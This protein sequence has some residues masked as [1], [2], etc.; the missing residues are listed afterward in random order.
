MPGYCLAVTVSVT[1]VVA[2]DV[3][4]LSQTAFQS[5][6]EASKHIDDVFALLSEFSDNLCRGHIVVECANVGS[7]WRLPWHVVEM[8]FARSHSLLSHLHVAETSAACA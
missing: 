1:V 5:P 8:V 6:A 7:R 3:D 4:G 2:E